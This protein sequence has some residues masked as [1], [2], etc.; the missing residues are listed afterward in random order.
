MRRAPVVA[1]AMVT[2]PLDGTGGMMTVLAGATPDYLP[3]IIAVEAGGPIASSPVLS[4]KGSTWQPPEG[5]CQLAL[6]RRLQESG[7]SLAN[8]STVRGSLCRRVAEVEPN[9]DTGK[10]VLVRRLGET[11]K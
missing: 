3:L 6:L 5:D 10:A 11:G 4:M 8:L 7:S 9:E 2:I 1:A